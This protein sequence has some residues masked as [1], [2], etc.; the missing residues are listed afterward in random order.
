MSGKSESSAGSEREVA[1]QWD[2][3]PGVSLFRGL[4]PLLTPE[5][6][7]AG[8]DRS[9]LRESR[10]WS[11]SWALFQGSSLFLGRSRHRRCP[12]LTRRG[13]AEVP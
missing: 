6:Q 7:K 4:V 13:N 8:K 1:T 12:R 10:R 11:A 9:A 2:P 3:F 5:V